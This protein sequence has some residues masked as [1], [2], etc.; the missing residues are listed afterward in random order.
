MHLPIFLSVHFTQSI[1][2]QDGCVVS[3]VM[4]DPRFMVYL[5]LRISLASDGPDFS[6]TIRAL[7]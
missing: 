5:A 1:F 6:Q 4:D 7:V 3:N 2:K